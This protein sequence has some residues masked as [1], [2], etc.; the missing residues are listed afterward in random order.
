M[1]AS[2]HFLCTLSCLFLLTATLHAGSTGKISGVVKDSQTEESL[3]GVNVVV[4]GTTLGASTNIEG[5]YV[6]LN[7]PPG[8][9]TVVAS[10]VGYRK[11]QI[12]DLNVS[13]DFTTPLDIMLE[14]GSVELDAVVVQAE[15]T[16]LIR[17]DLT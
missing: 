17:Q 14:E 15:R 7:V 4:Q 5:R 1:S 13:V 2:R 3:P 10:L 16:P 9:Y 11:F 8:N 12:K 6:I